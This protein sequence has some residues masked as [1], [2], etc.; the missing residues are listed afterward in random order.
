MA[1][2]APYSDRDRQGIKVLELGIG[3]GA[4]TGRLMRTCAEFLVQMSNESARMGRPFIELD[5]WDSNPRMVEIS[6]QRIADAARQPADRMIRPNLEE[7]EFDPSGAP[8][9]DDKYDLIVGS[10]FSHYWMDDR[11]NR[12]INRSTELQSFRI[13]LES[14]VAV[15]HR[16]PRA[17]LGCFLYAGQAGLRAALL[18][19]LCDE[20]AGLVGDY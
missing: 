12:G 11:P 4:F 14:P 13:F 2:Y 8:V 3:T 9:A 17:F 7:I 18:A 1:L 16:R 5:G 6:S 19:G 20:R 15:E 10:F